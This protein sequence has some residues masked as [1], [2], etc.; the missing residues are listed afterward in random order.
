MRHRVQS[1]LTPFSR[2]RCTKVSP[3]VESRMVKLLIWWLFSVPR[4]SSSGR[5]LEGRVP[6]SQREGSPSPTASFP[7]PRPSIWASRRFSACRW[8]SSASLPESWGPARK[9]CSSRCLADGRR[10]GS[11]T[12]TVFSDLT[13]CHFPLQNRW[14]RAEMQKPE[15]WF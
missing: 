15:E 10:V 2:W 6:K 1:R 9:G 12:K 14:Q 7:K 11:C 13:A 4:F 5:V 8:T 3:Q